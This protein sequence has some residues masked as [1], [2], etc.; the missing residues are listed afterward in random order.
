VVAAIRHEM[1]EVH[2]LTHA[3]DASALLA[4]SLY[5]V[6]QYDALGKVMGKRGVDEH[7]PALLRHAVKAYERALEHDADDSYA[8]HYLAFNLDVLA[9][10]PPRVEAEYREALRLRSD[11]VWYH[12]R[13]IPFLITRGREREARAA[14]D[15]ALRQLD[16]QREFGWLYREMH[17]PLARLLLHRGR[18]EFARQVLADVP[19]QLGTPW[20][21]AM[22]GLLRELTDAEA[23]LLVFP[24][25]ISA[26]ARWNGP[27][28]VRSDEER[29]QLK[30]WMPG[31]IEEVT[32]KEVLVRY[33]EST[34]KYG[35]LPY[36]IGE[37]RKA[38][39]DAVPVI[40]PAGTFVEILEFRTTSV[41]RCH[42]PFSI[43]REIPKPFPPP[44]R[45]LPRGPARPR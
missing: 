12:G 13:L 29:E 28:L 15:D 27:H 17:R 35:R 32:E 10:D 30:K 8:H 25:T 39:R 36:R 20:L 11:H 45:Y 4:R 21:R 2:H 22:Q 5:F 37:F 24:P 1:E 43:D 31:R 40:P 18:I 34:E 42:P 9:E 16:G 6:E 41:I 26:D 14:W 7:A 38:C 3:G 44:D 33:A 23:D 19:D